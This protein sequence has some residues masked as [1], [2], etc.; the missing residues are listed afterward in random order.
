MKRTTNMR[1]EKSYEADELFLTDKNDGDL[2]DRHVIPILNNLRKHY[3]K[4][5]YDKDKA[6]DAWYRYM[7]VV[8]NQYF[9]SFGY[10][11]SVTERF[12]AAVDMEEDMREQV[13]EQ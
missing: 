11:F 1:Y 12:T 6:V 2:W 3:K 10:R 7:T 13:E 9:K 5:R 4:G 8:S